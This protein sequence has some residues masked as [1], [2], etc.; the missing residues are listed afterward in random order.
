MTNDPRVTKLGGVLR[1]TGMDEL[2]QLWNVLVGDMA[3]V[4]P[5]PL[6]CNEDAKCEAWQRRRLDTKPGLTCIW[7]ISKSRKISFSDWMRMDLR[8]A[9]KR[10]I[11]GD[12]SLMFKTV[13]AV[14]FG[15][16]GH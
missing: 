2:P 15:R 9:D 14:L 3:I 6:P 5:R 11:A 16:V 7:Q 4:G 8:Y 12:I 10:T 13:L 1:K